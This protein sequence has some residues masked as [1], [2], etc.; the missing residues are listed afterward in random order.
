MIQPA[1]SCCMSSSIIAVHALR[2]GLQ[3]KR[4]VTPE[5]GGALLPR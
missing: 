2:A 4:L 1:S 5:R 3:E